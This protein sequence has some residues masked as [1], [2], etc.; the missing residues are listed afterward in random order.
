MRLYLFIFAIVLCISSCAMNAPDRQAALPSVSVRT[1]ASKPELVD[2]VNTH[3][4]ETDRGI[5]VIDA[6]RLLPEAERAIKHIRRHEKP[7]LGILI[8]HPHTDHYGGLPAFRAAFPQAPVY[9]SEIT[10]RSMRDDTRGFNAARKRRHGDLF[11]GQ[12]TIE[13]NLPQNTLADGQTLVF[14]GLRIT[15]HVLGASESETATLF[16]LADHRILFTGDLINNGFIPAPLEN[17][18]AWKIQ[19]TNISDRFDPAT[20][21]YLGHGKEGALAPLLKAQAAYLEDLTHAVDRRIEDGIL[22]A[23]EAS[24]IGFLLEAK[25][26]HAHAVGGN[27]REEVL[28]AVAGF[29]AKQ[30]GAEVTAGAAFR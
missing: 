20:T 27:A 25:Y 22:D 5:V 7:V 12:A 26:P 2:S 24:E 4:I 28:S 3:W 9:A 19:L 23:G 29:V 8:T 30:R 6:Q 21:A 16:H 11:P 18:N 14:E 13:A 1:Y 15:V 10:I 17:I